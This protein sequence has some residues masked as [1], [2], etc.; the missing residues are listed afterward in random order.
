MTARAV[1][2]LIGS[3]GS[4]RHRSAPGCGDRPARLVARWVIVTLA[5]L[6]VLT[7]L[8][9]VAFAGSTVRIADGVQIAGVDVG[10]LTKSEARTLLER[11]FE[12]VA[13][14][15][16][17]FTAG[18]D[19]FPIKATTL[20]VEADW[21]VGG[22][23]RRARGAR[24]SARSAASSGCRP[25]SSARR[26]CR[27]C[28]PTTRRSTTSSPSSPRKVDQRHVE[29]TL[30]RRG[31]RVEVVPGQAGR[32]LDRRTRRE[33]GS[34]ARSHGSSAASRSRCRCCVDPVEVTAA[35]LAPAAARRGSRCRRPSGS[36]TRA[37]AG[38]CLAG[39]SPSCSAC[40]SEARPSSRSP[41]R[42]PRRGSAAAQD[43]RAGA[44]RR[45][46]SWSSRGGDPRSPPTSRA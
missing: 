17:V 39:G 12:K 1:A 43:R 6:A 21:A 15:P 40:P 8:I 11:R 9:G 3:C 42:A 33:H 37:R 23:V 13:H 14:V 45:G 16:V 32:R 22:R 34:C 30:V 41:A 5:L 18:G 20:S 44:R 35:D 26:S 36:S 25:G 19:E 2:T 38:G 24:A 10:G 4:T 28:R 7:A 46:A 31:L 27:P 29:A